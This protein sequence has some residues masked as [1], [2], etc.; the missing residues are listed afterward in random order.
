MA[1]DDA[2]ERSASDALPWYADGLAF[3]CH[4]CGACCRGAGNV[5][6]SDAEITLLAR[7]LEM[8]EDELRLAYTRRAGPR[9]R[10]GER[11][12]DGPD[13]VLRQQRNQDCVFY[14]AGSGCSIYAHRPRQCRTYPFWEATLH[15]RESFEAEGLAC[16]GIGCGGTR[17]ADEIT[18]LAAADGIPRHRTRLRVRGIEEA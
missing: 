13:T 17:S 16:R 3:E 5:W 1:G 9:R 15:T 11:D 18:A 12:Q 2:P 4:R 6:I 7:A 10:G 14:A 8:N